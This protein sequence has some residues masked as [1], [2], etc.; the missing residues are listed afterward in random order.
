[1]VERCRRIIPSGQVESFH[2]I[3]T[4]AG[5]RYP[6]RGGDRRGGEACFGRGASRL[7]S[8]DWKAICGM[9]DVLIHDYIG[10]DLDEVW[11]VASSRIPNSSWHW[12]SIWA[13]KIEAFRGRGRGDFL[14]SHDLEDL[15]FVIDGRSAI[16]EEVQTEAPL[17]REY[18]RT[19]IAGLP[20]TPGFIDA[21]PGYLLPDAA[22]QA[23]SGQSYDD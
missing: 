2:G 22:S 23:R 14:A 5:R 12:I 9:R 20:A 4:I 11:N 18:L 3:R 8:L 6:E 13:T 21:L 17:L 16:V 19:E 10:V 1:M 15:I 7:S